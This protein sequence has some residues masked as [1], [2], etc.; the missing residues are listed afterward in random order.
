[1]L[2]DNDIVRIIRSLPIGAIVGR[3][4]HAKGPGEAPWKTWRIHIPHRAIPRGRRIYGDTLEEVL[5][6]TDRLL[7]CVLEGT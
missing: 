2:T 7:T 1:M 4:E 6:Q 5:I 3:I